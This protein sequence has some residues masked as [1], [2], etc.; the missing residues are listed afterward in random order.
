[1]NKIQVKLLVILKAI[2]KLF[3]FSLKLPFK[4]KLKPHT[5]ENSV[6]KKA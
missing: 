4:F 5:T 3:V 1:M 2:N 6:L